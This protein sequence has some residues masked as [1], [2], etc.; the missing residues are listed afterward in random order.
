MNDD[1]VLAAIGNQ[2]TDE[3]V[4]KTLTLAGTDVDGDTLTFSAVVN[5]GDLTANVTGTTLDLVPDPDWNG[6]ASITVTVNDGNGGT[7][8]ETFNLTV[9]GVND[10]PELDAI[11]NQTTDEDVTKT[12][13]FQQVIRKAT[14]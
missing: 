5:S 12:L 3:D 8:S 4:T 1:P 9:N 10:A 2:T 7:D 13:H 11:G 14:H 6:T